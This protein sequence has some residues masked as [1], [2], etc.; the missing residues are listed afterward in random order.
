MPLIIYSRSTEDFARDMDGDFLKVFGPPTKETFNLKT[1]DEIIALGGG[2]VI[3]TAKI[4][5]MNSKNKRIIGIPTTA[6]GATETSHAVY[7]DGHRKYSVRTPKPI[8]KIIPAFLRTLPKN[9]IR[10]TSYDALSQALESYWSKKATNTSRIFARRAAEMVVKQIKNDYPDL[11]KLIEGGNLSG[12]AIEIT[13]T[14]IAHAISYPITGFYDVPHGLAVGLV[15]PAVAKYVECE[16]GVPEYKINLNKN[17]DINLI[18]R[19][20]MTYI[21]IHD[22][23]KDINKERVIK[24]LEESL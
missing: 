14:N 18:A 10:A 9:I 11:E 20:A 21:Q 13:G 6:S 16:L 7:W 4:I 23:I 8:L 3:D 22:A 19:E 17:F 1:D 12:K 15:L 24:I 2:S 5:A